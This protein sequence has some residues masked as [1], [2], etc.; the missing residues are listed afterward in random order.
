MDADLIPRSLLRKL[1]LAL[2]TAAA[3]PLQPKFFLVFMVI[4]F[5]PS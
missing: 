5:L 1:Q 2:L 3:M 4:S